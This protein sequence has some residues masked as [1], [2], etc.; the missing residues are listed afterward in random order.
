MILQKTRFWYD[1]SVDQG[2]GIDRQ[3]TVHG[4]AGNLR[5]LQRGLTGD[6]AR[7]ASGYMDEPGSL[8]AYLLYY[9]AVSLYESTLILAELDARHQLPAIHSVLDIGSGPGPASFAAN[10]FGAEKAFLVD[11]SEK[12][13]AIARNIAAEG[14]KN[15]NKNVFLETSFGIIT[16]CA[17]LEEFRVPQGEAFDLI[18]ASHS[19]NELWHGAP[20]WL[21]RRRDFLLRLLPALRPGGVLLIVEPSAHYTS[22]P[23]L[24]LRDA[25]L[26]ST[27]AQENAL[28]CVGPCP[29]SQCCPMLAYEG[30]PCFPNGPGYAPPL[31]SELARFAGLDRSLLKAHGWRSERLRSRNSTLC[32]APRR[33]RSVSAAGSS[34]SPCATRRGA[35][36][37][38]SVPRKVCSRRFRRPR[39]MRMPARSVSSSSPAGP[40]RGRGAGEARRTSSGP[41]ARNAHAPCDARAAG[42]AGRRTTGGI[43][44]PYADVA[45]RRT[46]PRPVH[47]AGRRLQAQRGAQQARHTRVRRL[48]QAS[49]QKCP[50]VPYFRYSGF[51]L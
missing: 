4:I 34:Q 14:R 5:M 36:G 13:L 39:T 1:I 18:V 35:S 32:G 30:R 15:V 21:E 37:T 38:L 9:W 10:V 20:D 16:Q 27:Q 12:A 29:H 11:K 44:A 8:Q 33:T 51:S 6:R 24:A 43:G 26:C 40:D 48:S 50:P 28:V 25:L 19:L 2:Y 17:E 41:C 46:M 22:I 3:S 47:V 23:L 49:A 31:V 42:V 45:G 7:I